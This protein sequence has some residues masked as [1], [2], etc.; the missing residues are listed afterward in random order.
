MTDFSGH[1]M[2]PRK[3]KTQQQLIPPD[4][5]KAERTPPILDKSICCNAP[6]QALKP[7]QQHCGRTIGWQIN[8]RSC[9]KGQQTFHFIITTQFPCITTRLDNSP[10]FGVNMHTIT[11]EMQ[12]GI[13][14]LALGSKSTHST[15][16]QQLEVAPT[17]MNY[18]NTME[19]SRPTKHNQGTHFHKVGAHTVTQTNPN[20]RHEFQALLENTIP[21]VLGEIL[22]GT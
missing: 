14:T 3:P 17:Q 8:L 19:G 21:A 1:D 10:P 16:S 20:F 6:A 22:M 9:K 5:E 7:R 18:R 4:R 11:G 2:T 15:R 13:G 12:H